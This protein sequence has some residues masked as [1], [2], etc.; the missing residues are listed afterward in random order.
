MRMI[1]KELKQC[2]S[3]MEEHEIEIVE[4]EETGTFK[5]ETVTFNATYEYCVNAD[6]YSETEALMKSN[7]LA[8]KDAYRKQVGLL[9][10]TE[11][12]RIRDKYG[13]SQKEFSDVLGWSQA[14]IIRYEN[15]QVQDRAH[16]DILR[17][18]D[19]DP[20]WFI[21]LLERAKGCVSKYLIYRQNAQK[22]LSTQISPYANSIGA[23]SYSCTKADFLPCKRVTINKNYSLNVEHDDVY[24]TEAQVFQVLT[25]AVNAA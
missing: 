22:L 12:K 13:I 5:G 10:S 14:T 25:L 8:Q 17:K 11:I 18:L 2:F 23:T 3:C 20:K 7:S 19:S 16:D 9:T 24:R 4:V 1:K 6:E 21:E 15:H